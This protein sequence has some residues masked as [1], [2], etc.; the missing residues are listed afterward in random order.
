MLGKESGGQEIIQQIDMEDPWTAEMAAILR[1]ARGIESDG[2]DIIRQIDVEHRWAARTTET[3]ETPQVPEEAADPRTRDP[4]AGS[5]EFVR[6][7]CAK[8]SAPCLLRSP[9]ASWP[10][11]GPR[12]GLASDLASSEP[13]RRWPERASLIKETVE[14]HGSVTS[15]SCYLFGHLY[16]TPSD[17]QLYLNVY[18]AKLQR[19]AKRII[20]TTTTALLH[21][22]KKIA[23][24]S[25]G[26]NNDI[27]CPE[28]ALRN[29]TSELLRVEFRLN[30]N[31][32]DAGQKASRRPLN[33][34]FIIEGISDS[35]SV[36][37]NVCEHVKRATQESSKA[38]ENLQRHF[39]ILR[40]L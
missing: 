4:R 34:S 37:Q 15:Q 29:L 21:N 39:D 12:T 28:T 38:A 22:T 6:S 25:L 31:N 26:S 16:G 19:D 11:F 7:I 8:S 9:S 27:I 1:P 3:P 32:M 5:L 33:T 23:D 20:A 10:S 13:L 24:P 40:W 36:L 35:R 14:H 18:K 17:V 2:Q 30:F